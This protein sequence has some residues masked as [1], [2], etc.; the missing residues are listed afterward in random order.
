MKAGKKTVSTRRANL[1]KACTF[2][3]RVTFTLPKR[4]HPSSLRVFVAFR[5][6]TVL[7]PVK[8]KT[9]SIKVK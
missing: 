1:T 7:A 2:S 6:N 8:F 4:L 9:Y 3:S 5:G